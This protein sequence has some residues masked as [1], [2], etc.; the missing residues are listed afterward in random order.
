MFRS[1]DRWA[2]WQDPQKVGGGEEEKE[3]WAQR[4][5]GKLYNWLLTSEGITCLMKMAMRSDSM[6]ILAKGK[7][8][9]Q[10]LQ[11]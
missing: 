9:G 6:V 5:G 7:S 11:R 4:K 8:R 10:F 1:K 2:R 3:K